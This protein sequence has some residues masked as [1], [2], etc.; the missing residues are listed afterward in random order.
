MEMVSGDSVSA[1]VFQGGDAG[2]HDADR[3][4]LTSR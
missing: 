4:L 3:E 1:I 2:D